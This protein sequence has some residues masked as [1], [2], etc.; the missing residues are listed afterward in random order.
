MT[1]FEQTAKRCIGTYQRLRSQHA[2]LRAA[3]AEPPGFCWLPGFDNSGNFIGMVR[4]DSK[5]NVLASPN[6]VRIGN[7][8]WH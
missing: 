7:R 6:S 4:S 8:E 2:D 1:P 5:V 3:T